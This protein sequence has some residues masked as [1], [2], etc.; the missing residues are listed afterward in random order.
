MSTANTPNDSFI[1]LHKKQFQLKHLKVWG[2]F[3][4]NGEVGNLLLSILTLIEVRLRNLQ[5]STIR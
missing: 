1:K 5:R 3:P 2:F 4:L